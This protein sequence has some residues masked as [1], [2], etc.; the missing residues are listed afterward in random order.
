MALAMRHFEKPLAAKI[1][2]EEFKNRDPAGMRAVR[3]GK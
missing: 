2:E 3:G 1:R